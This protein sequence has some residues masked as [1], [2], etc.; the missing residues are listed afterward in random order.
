MSLHDEHIQE[1][2]KHIL[3]ETFGQYRYMIMI[4]LL[5]FAS[6]ANFSGNFHYMTMS[7]EVTSSCPF[8]MG[9]TLSPL[10]N[11]EV[12]TV[13]V[14][15]FPMGKTLCSVHADYYS[16]SMQETLALVVSVSNSG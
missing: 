1:K 5:L 10:G 2:Q 4:L 13:K 15:P 7:A 6:T 3:T 16:V 9:R 14:C 8:T 12:T 11:N